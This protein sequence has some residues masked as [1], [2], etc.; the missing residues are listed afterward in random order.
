M[1]STGWFY[2]TLL[3]LY[4]FGVTAYIISFI[5]GNWKVKRFS[6]VHFIIVWLIQTASIVYEVFMT[7]SFP[8]IDFHEGVYFYAWLLLTFTLVMNWKY[9]VH[10]IGLL[11]NV[12]TFFVMALSILLN[13]T[14]QS[15]GRSSRFM[16]EILMAHITFSIVS[17]AFFTISFLLATMYLIQ[18]YLLKNK[19]GLKS[20]WRFINLKK[21]DTYSYYGI[22]AGVPLLL[23]GLLLG[24]GWAYFSGEQFYWFDLKT[25]GSF[26]LLFI[27]TLYLILRHDTKYN[28]LSISIYSSATFLVLLVNFFLF[29]TLSNF[30]F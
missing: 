18:Y 4:A 25:I 17:Y 30:H 5:A 11:T 20:M 10:L 13:V 8:F 7:K 15:A 12:F 16:H 6:F 28:R 23:I 26:I 29:S 24:V 22:V 3:L 2:E 9:Q 21:L 27:Y 1:M 19:K 14:S